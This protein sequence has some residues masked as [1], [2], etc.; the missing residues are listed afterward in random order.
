MLI[1]IEPD[2]REHKFELGKSAIGRNL[3]AAETSPP[4]FRYRIERCVLEELRGTPLDP[5]EGRLAEANAELLDQ[6]GLA[7]SGLAHNLHELP[8]AHAGALP[9][10]FQDAEVLLAADERRKHPSPFPAPGSA[11]SHNAVEGYR[12]GHAL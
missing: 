8:F 12:L 6:S 11:R 4:P 10:P 3:G 2:L 7:D 5:G 1:R 9:A